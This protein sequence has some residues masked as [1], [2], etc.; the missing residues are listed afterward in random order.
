MDKKIK[1]SLGKQASVDNEDELSDVIA[2]IRELRIL[3]RT[4]ELEKQLLAFD[5][6]RED[7]RT[8]LKERGELDNED[9]SAQ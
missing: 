2:K 3:A 1:D 7:I 9:D 6:Q 4:Y 5:Y 8:I